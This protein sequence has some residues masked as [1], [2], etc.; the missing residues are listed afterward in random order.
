[1]KRNLAQLA[2]C[3]FDLV[4]IGGGIF[5]ACAAWD[6]AQRGLSVA[7]IDRGDFCSATSANH[8]K[9]VHGGIRYLQHGD[10]YRL[11]QSSG[12]RRAFLRIAPHLVKP[13]PTVIPTYGSGMKGK[14]ILRAGMGLYD[15]LTADRNR[16]IADRTRHIPWGRSLGKDE[17]TR[18][19]PGLPTAGLTGAAVFC[20]GQM[21][22]P[23]R[24]VLGILQGAVQAGARIANY[25][26]A[27]GFVRRGARVISLEAR[28]ALSGTDFEIRARVVLNAAGPFAEGLLDR[29]LRTRLIPKGIYSRDVCFVVSRKLLD[30]GH[31]LAVQGTTRDPDAKFSRGARHLFVAPWRDCTLVGVW[32]VVWEKDPDSVV[33]TDE[34][35]ERFIAEANGAC[36]SLEISLDDV[37]LWN[38]GLVPFGQNAPG[39][40]D[41]RYGHRS[42][43]I[44]H[45]GID[46]IQNV[47]TLIGVRFTTGRFEAE[48]AVDLVF[49]KL[50]R[51]PRP[52]RTART[53]VF[54][55]DIEQFETYSKQ[56]IHESDDIV[57]EDVVRNLVTNYGTEFREVLR[58]T[59]EDNSL[60]ES[61]GR[62]LVIKAQVVHAVREEMAQNLGD[63]VFRRTDLAT[64]DYPG[65]EALRD[66]ANILAAELGWAQSRIEQEVN[67]AIKRFRAARV[68]SMDAMN[69][70]VAAGSG[71]LA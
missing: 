70:A 36:P 19:F 37:P 13:L 11:R 40:K 26:A 59:Y 60:S 24:L 6:A 64:G 5:G 54:G 58:H 29:T 62:S 63:V 2:D 3:E 35:L 30:H 47:I 21:H 20:D 32:H 27:T 41:L 9:M 34:E 48:R 8:L 31:A 67:G 17:V 39:S 23:P 68:R 71:N 44:D 15:L 43:L 22:N 25:V 56:A 16:G 49:R 55:G 10:I 18:M 50:D 65:R 28:D 69:P 52:C 38:A 4:V 53:P 45:A 57:P 66:C 46:G 14:A 61:V 33:V 42:R 7:L 51:K 1:V 12:E